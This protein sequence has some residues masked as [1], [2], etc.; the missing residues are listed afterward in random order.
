MIISKEIKGY[1]IVRIIR[2]IIVFTLCTPV[3]FVTVGC[4][5]DE[6]VLVDLG[7]F[8]D[9]HGPLVFS[10]NPNLDVDTHDA[11]TRELSE[12]HWKILERFAPRSTWQRIR[13]KKKE[14]LEAR[15]K[16]ARSLPPVS[17]P[18][19]LPEVITEVLEGDQIQ[20]AS[21]L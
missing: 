10:A 12:A 11:A 14:I 4:S 15:Q 2:A 19:K 3:A 1:S 16:V 13:D 8:S 9:R 18:H 6:S 21:P 20:I 17:G 7:D 5:T